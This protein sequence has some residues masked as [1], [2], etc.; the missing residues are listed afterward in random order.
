MGVSLCGVRLDIE[1]EREFDPARDDA[2]KKCA[3]KAAAA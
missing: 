2:C 1:T 3:R